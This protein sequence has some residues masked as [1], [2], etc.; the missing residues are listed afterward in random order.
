MGVVGLQ[1]SLFEGSLDDIPDPYRGN[2][3][4]DTAR[5]RPLGKCIGGHSR[6]PYTDQFCHFGNDRGGLLEIAG[7]G[8]GKFSAHRRAA[9]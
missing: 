5:K 6:F 3:A 2:S 9:K 4:Q 8:G 7:I 1:K